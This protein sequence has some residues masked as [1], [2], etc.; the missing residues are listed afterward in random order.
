MTNTLLKV[1]PKPDWT[2]QVEFVDGLNGVFN[3]APYLSDEAFEPLKDI[4]EFRKIHNGGYF[5]EWE[6]GADLSAD[7]LRFK[8]GM[9]DC[10]VKNLSLHP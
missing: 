9:Q 10:S 3:V 7:T 2:L 6:C 4:A 8:M 5:I 1:T